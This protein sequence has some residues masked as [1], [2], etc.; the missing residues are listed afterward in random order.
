M[1]RPSKDEI[2]QL[3]PY[4]G[5]SLENIHIVEAQSQVEAALSYLHAQELVG[6]DTESKPV[7][8]KGQRSG[9]PKL[10]QIA[11]QDRVYLL[12]TQFGAAIRVAQSLLSD[13]DLVKLGFGL[14]GDR[15]SLSRFQIELNNALDLSLLLK[16]LARDRN[17]IGARAGVAMVLNKRL[18]KAEQ[19]SNWGRYPLSERQI[20]YAA[21]DAHCAISIGKALGD[22]ILYGR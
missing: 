8:E 12:P 11:S 9:G 19:R 22:D 1:R 15:Q 5:V 21:N 14:K 16:R 10:I 13:P 20:R 18:S 2:N 4:E 6:F 7:F 3:S 17:P